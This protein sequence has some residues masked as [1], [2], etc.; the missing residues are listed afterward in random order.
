MGGGG[1]RTR[2]GN[3]KPKKD[4]DKRFLGK[5][6]ST[7][8]THKDAKKG[9]YDR[10]TKI[11]PDGRATK[12]RHYTDHFSPAKHSNPHDHEINWDDT[13]GA[14][15]PDPPIN[16]PDGAPEFKNFKGAVVMDEKLNKKE[17]FNELNFQTVEEFKWA[18][19]HGSEIQFEWNNKDYSITHP[20]G[21]ISV[22]EGDKYSEAKDYETVNEA[23]EYII[24]GQRLKEIITKVDVFDRTI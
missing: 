2:S 17:D 22:C 21:I 1:E 11:G 8:R 19:D 5:P 16:Y 18:V 4:D 10:D 3:W 7:K 9:G 13:T 15:K 23:L 6:N 12:E 20:D 14:P 24:D